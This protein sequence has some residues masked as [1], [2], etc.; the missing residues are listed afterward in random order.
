M[1]D[2]YSIGQDQWVE[3]GWM[4]DKAWPRPRWY[5]DRMSAYGESFWLLGEITPGTNHYIKI[6][7]TGGSHWNW[8]FT[9]YVDG[10]AILRVTGNTVSWGWPVVSGEKWN[11]AETN[12]SDWWGL[13]A[14]GYPGRNN[15][16]RDWVG[17]VRWRGTDSRYVYR[18]VSRT[19][20]RIRPR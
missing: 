19:S 16:W 11:W 4:W 17:N 15:N 8:T 5:V 2:D 18:A 10:S 7:K 14:K 20:G 3:M 12:W 6:Y 9:A 13:R 1:Y